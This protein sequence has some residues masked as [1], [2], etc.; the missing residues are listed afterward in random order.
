MLYCKKDV[1]SFRTELYRQGGIDERMGN[2]GDSFVEKWHSVYFFIPV[3]EKPVVMPELE[4]FCNAMSEKFGK[5]TPLADDA[6]MPEKSADMTSFVLW[7]HPVYY[8]RCV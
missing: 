4:A 1:R 2:R 7:S 5:V 6:K 8:K 3:F